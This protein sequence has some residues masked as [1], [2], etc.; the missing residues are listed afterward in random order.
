MRVKAEKRREEET[1]WEKE[2]GNERIGFWAEVWLWEWFFWALVGSRPT[3]GLTENPKSRLMLFFN[4]PFFIPGDMFACLI[5]RRRCQNAPYSPSQNVELLG[6]RDRK[7]AGRNHSDHP[8]L[9]LVLSFPSQCTRNRQ[10]SSQGYVNNSIQYWIIFENTSIS[11]V[12]ENLST[13]L[14]KSR[15][16]ELNHWL[17][18]KISKSR[19]PRQNVHS[20]KIFRLIQ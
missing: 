7:I 10:V 14:L 16:L 5:A 15:H 17:G 1:E 3:G 8:R 6:Y 2:K 12:N 11:Y 19:R 18:Y 13:F 4:V 20:Q 9:V